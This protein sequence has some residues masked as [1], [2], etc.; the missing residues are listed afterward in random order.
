MG[1]EK[2]AAHRRSLVVVDNLDIAA[3]PRFWLNLQTAYDLEMIEDE[4]LAGIQSEVR[5]SA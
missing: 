1:T 4:T 5:P 2:V 3:T